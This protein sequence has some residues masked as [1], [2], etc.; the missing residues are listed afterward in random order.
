MGCEDSVTWETKAHILHECKNFLPKKL[1]CILVECWESY[2]QYFWYSN[3][4]FRNFTFTCKEACK[5]V[6]LKR[7]LLYHE[8][9]GAASRACPSGMGRQT[10]AGRRSHWQGPIECKEGQQSWT[11]VHDQSQT[12]PS[13]HQAH[14]QTWG[15]SKVNQGSQSA[16][17]DLEM[18]KEIR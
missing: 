18:K 2:T 5:E 3:F 9:E 7:F 11:G 17:Q 12:Q 10:L 15:E 16:A 13:I 6:F 1:C 8:C 4:L 14:P